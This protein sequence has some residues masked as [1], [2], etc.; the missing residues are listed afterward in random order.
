MGR[1]KIG[2]DAMSPM[3][4]DGKEGQIEIERVSCGMWMWKQSGNG[5]VDG[6]Q[7]PTATKANCQRQRA[8][9]MRKDAMV[10]RPWL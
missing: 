3:D 4:R 2:V 7:C 8:G 9:L 6:N 1:P 5:K 10:L